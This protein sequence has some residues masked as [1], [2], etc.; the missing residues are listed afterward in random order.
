[1]K[2]VF[3]KAE[4]QNFT[5]AL[6]FWDH[7]IRN[8]EAFHFHLY[9]EEFSAQDW[10]TEPSETFNELC[11]QRAK[12]IRDKYDHVRLWYSAGRDSHHILKTFVENNI[13]IDELLIMD[14]SIMPRFATDATIAYE[15]AIKTYN[16][17]GV[18][19]PIIS[20]LKPGKDE[21]NAYFQKDW[22]LKYG[23]YGCNY[24]FNLN[25]YPSIVEALPDLAL[26]KNHCEVFGFEK[27]KVHLDENGKFFYMM[28]DKNFNQGLG[29]QDNLEWFYLSGDLPKL[30]IKQCHLLINYAEDKNLSSDYF[31]SMQETQMMYDE[32]AQVMARGSSISH[33]TG[34]GVNKTFGLHSDRYTE[35]FTLAT[36]ESWKSLEHYRDFVYHLGQLSNLKDNKFFEYD[37]FSFAGV[38]T[39]KYYL[40]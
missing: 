38:T 25:H 17:A 27:C 15:T 35:I 36:N 29:N 9:D 37:T 21:F 31:S 40:T 1:M 39:K 10:K 11:I 20:I 30:A 19:I 33:Q 2:K 28:N 13:R 26:R 24:N 6:K 16:E 12:M 34:G 4:T 5:N 18:M 32:F 3:Y 7:V 23:G 14:W 22:F 8:N